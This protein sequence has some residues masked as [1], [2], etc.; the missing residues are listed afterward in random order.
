MDIDNNTFEKEDMIN[1]IIDA[2]HNA[3]SKQEDVVPPEDYLTTD[4]YIR[5]KFTSRLHGMLK[6][7]L[8]S[9]Y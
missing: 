8:G 4:D 2:C 7:D 1:R 3:P 6:I 9:Y 5:H